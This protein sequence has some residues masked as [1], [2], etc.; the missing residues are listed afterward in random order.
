[1]SD[2]LTTADDL[3][4][5]SPERLWGLSAESV[6]SALAARATGEPIRDRLEPHLRAE[7]I[8][9]NDERNSDAVVSIHEWVLAKLGFVDDGTIS[10]LGM[11]VL[12]SDDPQ[13]F[14]RATTVAQFQSAEMVLRSCS[15]IEDTVPRRELDSLLADEWDETVLAPLLGSL[16][17]LTIYPDSVELERDRIA[18]S[19]SAQQTQSTEAAVA[20][21]YRDIFSHVVPSADDACLE[22]LVARVTA[23]DP[24][25]GEL[26]VMDVATLAG[27]ST[28]VVD[29]AD[30]EEVIRD[31]R[32]EYESELDTVRSLLTPSPESTVERV[33]TDE[34]VPFDTQ[35]EE[36]DQADDVWEVAFALVATATAHPNLGTFDVQFVTERWSSVTPYSLYQALSSI[37]G[38]D[39]DVSDGVVEFE[40]VPETVDAASVRDEYMEYLVERCSMIQR[41]VAALSQASV[42]LPPSPVATESM[43][44]QE[45]ESIDSGAVAP[46]YFTYTLVD[47]DALGEQKMDEYV[48]ESRGLGRERARLRRWH[49]N[50]SSGLKTY[51]AMTDRLFSLGL[52]RDVEEQILR[53]MTPFD[54]DTFNEYV[55]QIRRLL[56]QGFELRLLTR[57][58][59]ESWEWQRLQ[60]NLLSEIKE[61]RDQVTVRTYSRFKEHQRVTPDMD[62]RD[63]GEFG[64][65]GKLQTIGAPGE[66][67]AL[68]GSA[69]F[70]ENSYDWN[71]ECG[72]YTERTQFVDAAIEFF[73]IVWDISAADEVAMER[74]REVPD[75]QLVPTYY[76]EW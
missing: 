72:V 38:V 13:P 27:T 60:R 75:P 30:L 4:T 28:I 21:A 48:G 10:L 8:R 24:T 43:V 70:M 5:Q 31:Q 76:T 68:L 34:S 3:R 12:T 71:P 33:A 29:E 16:G 59:K 53:I 11:V 37:S 32:R 19:L 36:S 51:T 49:D 58:T 25:D 64:I 74:L 65:H 17:F 44:V 50:R 18:T 47:P 42:S 35:P 63:L 66:G 9:T 7:T 67:A 41:R 54:D 2:L 6:Y 62:F 26:V 22:D 73:D 20:D 45:Y 52:E 57:H 1:M 69:N 40:T 23:T 61:H 14:I 55:A 15:E 46:T 56:K 39:C